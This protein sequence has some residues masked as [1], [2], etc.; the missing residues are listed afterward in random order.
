MAELTLAELTLGQSAGS[1]CYPKAMRL[2]KRRDFVR[3]QASAVAASGRD[4]L[5][6]LHRREDD[7][8]LRFGVVASKKVGNAVRRNRGKRLVREWFRHVNCE[9]RGC[10]V[11][12][13]VRPGAP[14]RQAGQLAKQLDKVLSKA[15]RRL[16][17][18]GRRG[19]P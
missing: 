16:L 7:G 19:R 1:A 4:V 6:L 9:I 15:C 8:P 3:A 11:V 5:L 14:Q 2:R 17:A 13:V 18:G 12:V 10:D